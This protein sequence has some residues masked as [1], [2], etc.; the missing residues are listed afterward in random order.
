MIAN[1]SPAESDIKETIST[2]R[3]VARAKKI[4]CKPVLNEDKASQVI[5]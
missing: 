4:Q 3:Y 2:L 1:V 5:R